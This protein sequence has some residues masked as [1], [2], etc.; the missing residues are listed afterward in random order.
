M[1]FNKIQEIQNDETPI[2]SAKMVLEK[3]KED[4]NIEPSLKA[5]RLVLK[6]DFKLSHLKALK[7]NIQANSERC[8]VQ[9]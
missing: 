6:K 5:I 4:N 7:L 3:L 9:R 1:I 8:I 2:N